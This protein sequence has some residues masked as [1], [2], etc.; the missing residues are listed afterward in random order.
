MNYLRGILAN[1]WD[2]IGGGTY[3]PTTQTEL[4]GTIGLKTNFSA[5]GLQIAGLGGLHVLTGSTAYIDAGGF[6]ISNGTQTVNGAATFNAAVTISAT[7]A[8]TTNAAST[9]TLNGPLAQV[10]SATF[11]STI[12]ANGAVTIGAT[13]SLATNAAAA[14]TLAG[15]IT[16]TGANSWTGAQT[17]GAAATIVLSPSR[18]GSRVQAAPKINTTTPNGSHGSL[19]LAV[20]DM[21]E[22]AVDVDVGETITDVNVCIDA[23]VGGAVAASRVSIALIKR[24]ISGGATIQSLTDPLAALG[25]YRTVHTITMTLSSPYAVL[26]TEAYYVEVTGESG[27]DSQAIDWVGTSIAASKASINLNP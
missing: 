11:S 18:T 8:I 14:S 2:I 4:T 9:T 26:S 1:A 22:Q 21:A 25:T 6:F 27:L 24:T 13:G 5:T 19:P 10:G 7:G 3:T 20:S 15:P 12:A 17:L 16:S 23:S